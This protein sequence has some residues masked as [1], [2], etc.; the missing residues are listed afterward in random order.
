[1]PFLTKGKTN[2][3]YILIV[4]I[5]ALIVGGG[6]LGYL[7]YFKREISS[8]SKFPKIKKSE[9]PKIEE[10]IANWKT[11]R[12]EEY[13]FEIKYP[14]DWKVEIVKNYFKETVVAFLS[15]EFLKCREKY[16]Y[17]A[18]C[19]IENPAVSIYSSVREITGDPNKAIPEWLNE[20]RGK[21]ESMG[22]YQK[23]KIGKYQAIEIRDFVKPNYIM[24]FLFN[25]IDPRIAGFLY[26]SENVSNL[27]ANQMLSTFKFIE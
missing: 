9:K 16:E 7:R 10:E 6:I 1:M 4:A 8:L 15:P 5:L 23:I 14:P 2:W 21:Y 13:G 17:D 11:Y 22:E 27:I 24:I 18:R 12:N 25:D 20:I 19:E 26:D 3:K